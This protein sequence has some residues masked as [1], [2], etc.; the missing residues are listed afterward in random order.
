MPIEAEEAIRSHLRA[1]TGILKTVNL[2]G[3]GSDAVQRIKKELAAEL[4]KAA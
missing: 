2:V 1:D 4:P 3:F